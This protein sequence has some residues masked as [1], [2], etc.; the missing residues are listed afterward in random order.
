M[1]GELT[2]F[3]Y[4]PD[5]TLGW[6]TFGD[7]R[8]ATIEEPWIP[9]P[10]GIGGSRLDVKAGTLAS[11][12]PDGTYSLLP[13]DG[14]RFQNVFVM[15]NDALGVYKLPQ[16]IPPG[17]KFGRSAC[18]IHA[19]NSVKDIEGC[20]AIGKRHVIDANTH[21]IHESRAA[22]DSLRALLGRESHTLTIK[23]T[24]GTI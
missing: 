20:I 15:V 2:R 19:G 9:N 10:L 14:A 16:L 23:P 17:Q 4:L 11:C 8:L 24:R 12:I 5:C 7:L 13:F 1:R 22:L 6:L 18:L 3:G 21:M